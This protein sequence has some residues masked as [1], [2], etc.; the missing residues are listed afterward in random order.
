MKF[1]YVKNRRTRCHVCGRGRE[2]PEYLCGVCSHVSKHRC[3]RFS[4]V[5]AHSSVCWSVIY[6][7]T[8]VCVCVCVYIY[9]CMLYIYIYI[10]I[11]YICI[12]MLYMYIYMYIYIYIYIHT[13]THTHTHTHTCIYIYVIYTYVYVYI[14]IKYAPKPLSAHQRASAIPHLDVY[15]HICVLTLYYK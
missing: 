11:C 12:Y 5:C 10:Y 15:V 1:T 8:Y 9:I 2:E 4:D 13:R 3:S 6:I 14:F 7:Y